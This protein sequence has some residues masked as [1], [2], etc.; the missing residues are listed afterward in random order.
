MTNEI[1]T[2][3]NCTSTHQ[4]LLPTIKLKTNDVVLVRH[5]ADFFRGFVVE[6]VSDTIQIQLVD[7]GDVIT[8]MASDIRYSSSDL[9]KTHRLC[10]PVTLNMPENLSEDDKSAV[11]LQLNKYC[12]NRFRIT[13]LSCAIDP[14]AVVDL[15]SLVNDESITSKCSVGIKKKFFISDIQQKN[16][17][18][19]N[20]TLFVVENKHLDRGLISCVLKSDEQQFVSRFAGL[21]E[22]GRCHL[23]RKP[24]YSPLNLELCLVSHPDPDGVECWYRAQY[25]QE[26]SND[27]AQVGLIDFGITETVAKSAI[28]EFREEFSYPGLTIAC[29]LRAKVDM[30][31]L[32]DVRFANYETIQAIKVKAM[33]KFHD[34]FLGDEFFVNE[35]D[36]W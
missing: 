34:V 5:S 22:F 32:D 20:L 35:Q 24:T 15:M 2:H 29:K 26:L 36:F 4:D 25:Q 23:N 12:H 30:E 6:S 8:A 17:D 3:S 21:T 10:I 9:T 7:M 18:G 27:R 16:I 31:L 11:I 14:N 33:G 19:D 28:R 13:S 1:F